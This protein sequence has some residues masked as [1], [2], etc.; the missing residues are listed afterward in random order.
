MAQCEIGCAKAEDGA[1]RALKAAGSTGDLKYVG[2]VI[3]PVDPI[4]ENNP[5][6]RYSPSSQ[7][8]KDRTHRA[9][10][11]PPNGVGAVGK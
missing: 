6:R 3:M 1:R 8:L 11:V 7:N 10:R 5:F 4:N 9:G 2:N